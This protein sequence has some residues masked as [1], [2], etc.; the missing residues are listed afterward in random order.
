[1]A[2]PPWRFEATTASPL[3]ILAEDKR[4]QRDPSGSTAYISHRISNRKKSCQK[5]SMEDVGL[6]K[7]GIILA[8]KE[9]ALNVPIVEK[10]ATGSKLVMSCMDIQRAIHRQS[11]VQGQDVSATITSLQVIM[12]PKTSLKKM[13]NELLGF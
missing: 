11:M 7:I 8:L 12:C 3:E 5:I 4:V 2:A 6:T 1:M 13:D 9:A 10:E